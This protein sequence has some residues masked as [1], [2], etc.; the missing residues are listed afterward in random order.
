MNQDCVLFIP[1]VQ[2]NTGQWIEVGIPV[3]SFEEASAQ[4]SNFPLGYKLVA[5]RVIQTSCLKQNIQ[6]RCCGR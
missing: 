2:T 1:Q 3:S 5:F 6:R 4:K